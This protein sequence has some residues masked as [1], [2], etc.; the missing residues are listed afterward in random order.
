MGCDGSISHRC[1]GRMKRLHQQ[2]AEGILAD[3]KEK[4]RKAYSEEKVKDK[5]V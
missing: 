4:E 3:K 5:Q 2:K 1:V